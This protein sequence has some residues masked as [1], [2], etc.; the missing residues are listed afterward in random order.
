MCECGSKGLGWG[1]PLEGVR[2]AG[3]V[4]A[5]VGVGYASVWSVRGWGA[6]VSYQ[7]TKCQRIQ[8]VMALATFCLKCQMAFRVV[9]RIDKTDLFMINSKMI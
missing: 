9:S 1:C 3:C 8:L 6:G 2:V 5:V 7:G 4:G